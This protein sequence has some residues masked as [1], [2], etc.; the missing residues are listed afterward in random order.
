MGKT[1][2][3]YLHLQKTDTMKEI[4]AQNIKLLLQEKDISIE[5]LCAAT[6]LSTA[7]IVSIVN[8]ELTP[9]L[10]DIDII[11][12][13][14][15]TPTYWFFLP[16]PNFLASW[17]LTLEELEDMVVHNPSLRGFMVG[18]M[19]ES[20]ILSSFLRNHEV[21]N[22]YKPDDH[23]RSHKCDLILTYKGHE[24]SFEIKSLQTN[25]VKRDKENNKRLIATF[26]CDAS[27]KRMIVLSN[28]HS[29][30]TTCLKYGDFDIVAINLFAFTGNWDYAFALNSEL[31]HATTSRS[32][33]N[34]IPD[35]DL[36]YLIKS[37][38]RITYPLQYP[39][40]SDPFILMNRLLQDNQKD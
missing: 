32:K 39:F 21:S 5:K 15:N 27:D 31:P 22:V 23:D 33:N 18:Y 24:F 2:D 34:V 9:T 26:Q 16:L 13:A 40:V 4:I 12:K 28:G 25:T 8:A 14:L 37:S 29:I 11:A 38:I 17:H 19:A 20:K 7:T 10:Q 30:N 35:E 36:K 6:K 1:Q 3:F